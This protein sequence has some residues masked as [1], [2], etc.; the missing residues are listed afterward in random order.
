MFN[1]P[2][3]K[4]KLLA[5]LTT[6][7][8]GCNTISEQ[9]NNTDNKQLKPIKS[10]YYATLPN[11]EVV[12]EYTLTNPTGIEVSIISYGGIITSLKT[13]DRNGK[14]AD[15]VLGYDSIDGYLTDSNFFGALIGR[16]GNRINKGQFTIDGIQ[17]QLDTNDGENHLHGGDV[18][19]DSKNWFVTPYVDGADVGLKMQLF[20]PDGDAG[21]PGNLTVQ[22]DYRLAGNELKIDYK[23]TTDKKTH[24]NL[25]QHSYFN[26]AGEGDILDHQ[27]MIPAEYITPVNSSLIPTGDFMPVKGTPFDFRTATPIGQGINQKNQQLEYG[28]GYDHNWVLTTENNFE[29]KLAA[30]LSE[31]KSGRVLEI[32]S[33]EPGIQFYSGNFLNGS[34]KGKGRTFEYRNGLCL[35][36][37]HFPDA[38]NQS[39]FQSTLLN[40]GEVY[41]TRMSYKFTTE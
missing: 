10:Q 40:P 33:E 13:P 36:P 22:V 32:Y 25:T 11:G 7:L 15:I 5:V 28:L 20:S 17:Y 18:G 8:A 12:T 14:L 6:V 41:H 37:Q 29:Y 19:Y 34:A 24:V 9:Q 1:S 26:L 31:E 27:L 16:Y 30:R 21:Y 2:I 3:K 4:I 38:P 35:E 23:A 39:R